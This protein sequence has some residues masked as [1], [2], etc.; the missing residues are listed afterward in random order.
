MSK[1][2]KPKKVT[3]KEIRNLVKKILKNSLK[4]V[5]ELP[6][7]EVEVIEINPPQV[8]LKLP[9]YSEGN[10]IR[11]NEVDFLVLEIEKRGILVETFYLDDKQEKERCLNF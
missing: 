2:L 10:L 9:F 5:T 8:F 1:K 6:K 7:I 4:G 3:E 11:V